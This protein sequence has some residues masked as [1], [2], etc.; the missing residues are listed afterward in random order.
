MAEKRKLSPKVI[1]QR[2]RDLFGQIAIK[3]AEIRELEDQ[4]RALQ[5]RCSHLWSFSADLYERGWDCV[6]CS[7][8]SRSR[9]TTGEFVR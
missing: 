7:A 4:V 9:P 8:T 3:Q 6:S 5:S 1:A 2:R